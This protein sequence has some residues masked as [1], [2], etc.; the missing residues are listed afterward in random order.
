MTRK[1]LTR[2]SPRPYYAAAVN[3]LATRIRSSAAGAAAA[4]DR[5]VTPERLFIYPLAVLVA[6]LL[7]MGAAIGFGDLPNV[8]GGQIVLPD[9]LAH[10]TGGRMLLDGSTGAL[11]DP[12]AQ[13]VVQANEVGEGTLAWFVSPPFSVYLYAPFALLDYGVAAIAWTVFSMGCLV[14]AGFLVRP[15]APRLFRD[16]TAVV[17]L[18]LLATQPVFELIGSGQDTGVTVLLWVG[19]IRLLLAGHQVAGGAVLALGLFKPQLFIVVPLV[20]IAQR[21]WRALAAWFATAA[22][23]GLL[24]VQA[25]GIN[26]VVDWVQ[27][28]SSDT[29]DTTIRTAQAW[30]MQSLP[31]F[32]SSLG[33]PARVGSII[34]VLAVLVFIRQLWRA[35]RLGVAEL[36][37][38]MLAI[39][40]TV[41][42]SPHLFVYD[43]VLALVPML[44]LVEHVNTRTVRLTCV[45]LFLLTWTSP[46]RHFVGG[47]LD[48]AWSAIPL[49]I[50]W[51]V[52]ARSIGVASGVHASSSVG[53]ARSRDGS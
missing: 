14:V 16:H 6:S 5:I 3:G 49:T 19:G 43:L 2:D 15:F 33:F 34:A 17:V 31:A 42:F 1:V 24:S 11:Y 35:R 10:W 9:F 18:V 29:F 45:A 44:W 46:A 50:V 7:V 38:W 26:G 12:T 20:L 28:L 27:V 13:R 47:P 48:V 52:L 8:A 25:V 21:R 36:P 51:I 41:V 30:K 23:L 22:G 37:M 4:A 39:A 40:A 53:P 32:A